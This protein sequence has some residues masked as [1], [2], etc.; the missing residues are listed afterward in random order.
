MMVY[1]LVSVRNV[2]HE[3]WVNGIATVAAS[4]VVEVYHVELRLYLVSSGWL[5]R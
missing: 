2:L 5:S 1:A 3:I 4:R